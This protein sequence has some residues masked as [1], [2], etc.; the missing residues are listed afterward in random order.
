[1]TRKELWARLQ[2][3]GEELGL[4]LEDR[5]LENEGRVE[6]EAF[7]FN[8]E[9]IAALPADKMRRLQ[10]LRHD[11]VVDATGT[12]VSFSTKVHPVGSHNVAPDCEEDVTRLW[13]DVSVDAE[14][15]HNVFSLASIGAALL[16]GILAKGMDPNVVKEMIFEIFPT[17]IEA[18]KALYKAQELTAIIEEE[19][20]R[21]AHTKQIEE[22]AALPDEGVTISDLFGDES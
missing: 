11:L 22:L 21:Y 20:L 1:M 4:E 15:L 17:P 13:L 16:S 3:I 8:K 10:E 7:S 6:G 19:N 14:D 2:A 9:K 12:R 18:Q 5:E